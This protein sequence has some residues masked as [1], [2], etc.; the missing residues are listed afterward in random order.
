[1]LYSNA[2]GEQASRRGGDAD[3]AFPPSSSPFA[4]S[5]DDT[6][7][8]IKDTSLWR[9]HVFRIVAYFMFAAIQILLYQVRRL[10]PPLF[11][12]F[13]ILP[14]TRLSPPLLSCSF[15]FLSHL[16]FFFHRASTALS[17]T[18]S[19]RPASPEPCTKE[20][21]SAT[22]PTTPPPPSDPR[23]RPTGGPGSSWAMEEGL[24]A[25]RS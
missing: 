13:P 18:S 4:R 11:P 10:P 5:L 21:P 7:L 24:R 20:S 16:S 22:P 3:P 8:Q 2:V 25:R 23:T 15:P 17:T 19:P 1:M 14:S 12:S 6:P 9:S